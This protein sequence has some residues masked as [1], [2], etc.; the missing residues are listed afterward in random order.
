MNNDKQFTK[1]MTLFE[2]TAREMFITVINNFLGKKK[3]VNYK[4]LVA[5]IL[6]ASQKLDCSMNI[7]D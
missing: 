1:S 5:N 6:K 7:M 2:R 4:D 3:P